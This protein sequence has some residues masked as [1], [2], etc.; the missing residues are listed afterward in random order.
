MSSRAA[1]IA[2]A[3]LALAACGSPQGDASSAGSSAATP[4]KDLTPVERGQRAFRECAV[5]HITA[6]PGT[7]EGDQKLIGPNLFG[8]VGRKAG[9]L[10]GF[11]YSKAM[12]ESAVVWDATTLDAY[13]A[14]PTKEIPGNRMSFA[15]EPDAQKRADIIA[16]LTSLQ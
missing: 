2:V 5:C 11:S 9:S 14:Q 6:K 7:P 4:A 16:F 10:E 1:L 12:R 3:A 15:G 8:V 13:I